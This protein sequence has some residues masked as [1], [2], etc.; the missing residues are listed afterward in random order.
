MIEF[1]IDQ[2]GIVVRDLDAAM[3]QYHDLHGWGPW[4][5][6]EYRA[7]QLRDALVDGRPVEIEYVGAEADV[8]DVIVELLE[9][10]SGPSVYAD[11]L[12]RHGEGIHHVG[13]AAATLEE[14]QAIHRSYTERGVAELTSGWIDDVWYF[15]LATTPVILEVW[16]GEMSSVKPSRRYP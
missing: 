4:E 1:R 3:R 9:P 5:V 8:G 7:P 11:W 13:H 14:A 2:I 12:E 16:A 10:I 15:Y 6:Y